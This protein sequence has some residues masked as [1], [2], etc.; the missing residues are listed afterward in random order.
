MY[1]GPAMGKRQP[2]DF[3]RVGALVLRGSKPPLKPKRK[4][5]VRRRRGPAMTP[6]ARASRSRM[7]YLA[8]AD[9]RYEAIG[10]HLFHKAYGRAVSL[11]FWHD[12]GAD[13]RSSWRLGS[14]W[15]T[16]RCKV[17]REVRYVYA[18]VGVVYVHFRPDGS[19]FVSR[20]PWPRSKVSSLIWGLYEPHP[21]T[22]P[23]VTCQCASEP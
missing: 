5:A 13:K 23:P 4:A 8:R 19:K 11:G 15:T 3:L 10:E 21:D 14:W 1:T 7:R 22:R 9:V 2:K 17:C 6:E 20:T 12:C 18:R 16:V